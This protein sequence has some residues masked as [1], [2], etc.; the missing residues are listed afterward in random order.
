MADD[1]VWF[2]Y[3][4]L[5][6]I[7]E[8]NEYLVKIKQKVNANCNFCKE[9]T[10]SITHLFIE[11]N[12]VKSFWTN[13][14]RNLQCNLGVDLN[15]NPSDIIF[16]ILGTNNKKSLINL[17]FLAAKIFSFKA[18]RSNGQLSQQTFGNYVK[19]IYLNHE[20]ASKLKDKHSTFIRNWRSI[21]SLFT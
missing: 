9:E 6:R 19:E 12:F 20:Y 18:S 21:Q 2:Q 14:K 8:T 16:G 11:C 1:L 15:I 5:N 3:R 13:L 17:V 7:L 10:E 4:L